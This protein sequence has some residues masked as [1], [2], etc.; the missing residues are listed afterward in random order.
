MSVLF[1]YIWYSAWLANIQLDHWVR[2]YCLSY[3]KNYLICYSDFEDIQ[4]NRFIRLHEEC[5][6]PHTSFSKSLHKLPRS[7]FKRGCSC[8]SFSPEYNL[9]LGKGENSI[10]ISYAIITV[11]CRCYHYFKYFLQNETKA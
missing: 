3:Q 7:L 10:L 11:H 8:H 9:Q 1:P 4:K 5:D 6:W 2:Y